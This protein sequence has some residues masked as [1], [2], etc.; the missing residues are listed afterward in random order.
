M[1]KVIKGGLKNSSKILSRKQ[2]S[3][4]LTKFLEIKSKIT[5]LEK[6]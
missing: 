2:R 6:H 3:E 4:K 5:I 1:F